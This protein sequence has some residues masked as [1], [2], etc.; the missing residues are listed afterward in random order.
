MWLNEVENKT[1]IRTA[2]C[3]TITVR[4]EI[5]SIFA[6]HTHYIRALNMLTALM[7]KPKATEPI[8]TLTVRVPLDLRERAAIAAGLLD[9][10]L[11]KEAR[12]FLKELISK[13]EATHGPIK[14]PA[15]STH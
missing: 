14:I 5:R 4:K 8:V 11:S 1:K 15:A 3:S 9:S 10:D 12:K 2:F 6:V 7:P 13:A